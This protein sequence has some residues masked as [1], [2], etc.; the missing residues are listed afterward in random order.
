M[1][2]PVTQGDHNKLQHEN[3]YGRATINYEF[4]LSNHSHRT[5]DVEAVVKEFT[6]LNSSRKDNLSALCE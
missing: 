5:V 4:I 1:V 3:I 6:S 2:C